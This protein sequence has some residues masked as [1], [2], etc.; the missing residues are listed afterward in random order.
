M[1]KLDAVSWQINGKTLLHPIDLT[2]KH[3]QVV[4][5][6]RKIHAGKTARPPT[7]ADIRPGF[8]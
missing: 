3:G 6:I 1:F 7:D 2:I 4:G 8:P 5:L